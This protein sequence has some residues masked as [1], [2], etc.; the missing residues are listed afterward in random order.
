MRSPGALL[1][2][3]L[4]LLA[5]AGAGEEGFALASCVS[6]PVPAA[7]LLIP[8]FEVDLAG[9]EGRTTLV[10]VTNA[11]GHSTLA[12]VVLWTDW[13][14]PTLAFDLVLAQDDVQTLN[15]RDLFAG[16]LPA[17]GGALFFGCTDP[18]TLPVLDT[19][20]LTALRR[21]HT[22]LP[23]AQNHCSGSAGGGPDLATG[24]VTIDVTQR[25]SAN[26]RY[27]SSNG[28]F[29]AGGTGLASDENLLLGDFFLVDAAENLAVGNEAVHIHADATRYGGEPA[30]FYGGWIGHSGDDARAPLGTRYRAR[31]LRGGAFSGGTDLVV[32]A[33]PSLAIASGVQCGER[34]EAVD[35]CQFLRF[36]PFDEDAT[37]GEWTEV[38]PVTEVVRRWTV[39][40]PEVPIAWP[41]G[42]VDFE[43][44]VL[45]GCTIPIDPPP[46][47]PVPLQSFVLPLHS[48][49]GR[50]AVG[51][52]AARTAEEL[53]PP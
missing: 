7:T 43:N 51:F 26:I 2:G 12:H 47:Q 30:T 38:S 5:L 4:L 10:A 52:N 13:G 37:A 53:C 42:F 9:A 40:G 36:V 14:V 25:C 24:Y 50:F 6:G 48:A 31:F 21:Q 44:K 17:T 8:Y 33:E 3:S 35:P 16:S 29:A 18:V 20:A 23:D 22:G 39:G 32:W 45:P 27:P 49:E 34:S 41:F 1:A 46:G 19:A 28:Y 11:G 15:L